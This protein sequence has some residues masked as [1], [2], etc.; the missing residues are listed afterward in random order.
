[1]LSP[2]PL[3]AAVLLLSILRWFAQPLLGGRLKSIWHALLPLWWAFPSLREQGR[4]RRVLILLA[5]ATCAYAITCILVLVVNATVGVESD[6]AYASVDDVLPGSAAHGVLRAGDVITRVAGEDAA[7]HRD[8]IPMPLSEHLQSPRP[9]ELRVLR[10]GRALDLSIEPRLDPE[11]Q[12]YRIGITIARRTET[13]TTLDVSHAASFPIKVAVIQLEAFY[14]TLQPHEVT[15]SGPVG[16]ATVMP[17]AED[18]R[19]DMQ[20]GLWTTALAALL[21]LFCNLLLALLSLRAASAR[22]ASPPER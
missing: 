10:Q 11:S 5:E 18:R 19:R 1:M 6:T 16:I 21:L 14:E 15:F 22:V 8:G 17:E 20:R 9:T 4:R 13:I 3:L 2:L 12:Q 7:I